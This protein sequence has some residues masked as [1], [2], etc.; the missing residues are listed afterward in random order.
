MSHG[1]N[2]VLALLK[3]HLEFWDRVKNYDV[4]TVV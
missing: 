2:V 4:I 1:H 3:L